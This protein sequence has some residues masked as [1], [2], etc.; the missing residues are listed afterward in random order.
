MDDPVE[1]GLGCLPDRDT[2]R[3]ASLYPVAV[4]ETVRV[5]R[6]WN[7][8]GTWLNQGNTGTCVGNGFGHRRA[9]GPVKV[10]GID[11]PWARKLYLEASALYWGLPDATMLKGTSVQSGAQ[12]LYNRGAIDRFEWVSNVDQFRYTLLEVGSLVLGIDWYASMNGPDSNGYITQ[13]TT[14]WK[15]GGHCLIINKID[16]APEDGSVPFVRLKNS[17]GINWANHGTVRFALDEFEELIVKGWV[18]LCLIHEL[19]R[20]S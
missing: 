18:D 1:Y 8:S 9:D 20:A 11:E 17:W 12:A 2:V 16:T 15:H 4:Q 6:S 14:T 3:A 7:Q 13:D 5:R 10:P 19:P